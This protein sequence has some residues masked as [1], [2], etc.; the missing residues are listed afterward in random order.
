MSPV[1]SVSPDSF[2]SPS[3]NSTALRC[4]TGFTLGYHPGLHWRQK[5][6]L[7]VLRAQRATFLVP[8]LRWLIRRTSTGEAITQYCAQHKIPHKVITLSP[9]TT[10]TTALTHTIPLPT[11]HLLTPSSSAPTGATIL[12]LHGGGF[13]NPLRGRAHLPFILNCAVSARAKE[14]IILEYA[15]APENPYPAQLVQSIASL[16]YLLE[17]LSLAPEK[18]ILA[19]DSAGGR[20]V[21]ALLAHVICP[22]PY[23]AP[24]SLDDVG[25]EAHGEHGR[26]ERGRGRRLKAALLISPFTTLSVASESFDLNSKRDYLGREQV[27]GFKTAWAPRADEV[28]ADLRFGD[29]I[30]KVFLGDNRV[31]EKALI[32]VGN[33]EVFVHDCRFFARE[34]I[35]A[36]TVVLGRDDDAAEVDFA[37]KEALLVECEDEVHVQVA[38][39]SAVGYKDGIMMKAVTAWMAYQA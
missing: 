23:A 20:L 6:A 5:L 35:G 2:F 21:G 25:V 39:D 16:R 24:L 7:V 29:S 27:L 15:L 26:K 14:V 32:T 33:A 13:V 37:G 4:I 19:G 8:I 11:L 38:L 36:D 30:W 10:T 28:W 12:Y 31:V 1:R 9:E 18:V 22:C 34:L 3:N 17:T